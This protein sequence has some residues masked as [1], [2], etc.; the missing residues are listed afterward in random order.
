MSTLK[1]RPPDA[2]PGGL[3]FSPGAPAAAL[4]G[5][6]PDATPGGQG[7]RPGEPTGRQATSRAGLDSEGEDGWRRRGESRCDNRQRTG[8][9]HREGDGREHSRR[10]SQLSRGDGGGRRLGR[11][12][13]AAG[14]RPLEGGSGSR[15]GSV[16]ARGGPLVS[17]GRNWAPVA[18]AQP[19]RRVQQRDGQ[20]GDA[21]GPEQGLHEDVSSM[22]RRGGGLQPLAIVSARP[23]EPPATCRAKMER[24]CSIAAGQAVSRGPSPSR[25]LRVMSPVRMELDVWPKFWR[26]RP[27]LPK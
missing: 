5:R 2:T 16:T 18:E 22:N 8:S 7:S 1:G 6:P 14:G 12:D 19:G 9:T 10:R 20:D 26:E 15:L 21:K 4:K 3:G 27:I 13:L 25:S 11:F 24:L 17:A 23:H